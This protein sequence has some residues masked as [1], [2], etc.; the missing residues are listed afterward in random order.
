[1]RI[2]FLHRWVGVHGGGTETHIKALV[3][4]FLERG[5]EV[6]IITRAGDFPLEGLFPKARVWRVAGNFR[7]SDHSYEDWRVY[8]HTALFIIKL[9]IKLLYLHFRGERFDVLSVHF[10]TEAVVARV[11]RALFKTPFGNI[12]EGY[13][14][15]E[16]KVARWADQP[17]TISEY[18]AQRYKQNFGIDSVVIPNGADQKRF[19]ERVDGSEIRQKYCQDREKLVVTV[20]RLEPR[21]D[22]PTLLQAAVAAHEKMPEVRFVIAGTGI[23]AA[24]LKSQSSQLNTQGYVTFAG[25]VSDEDLPRYYAAADLFVLPT[26][27]EGFG[28]VYAEAMSCGI[29]ILTTDIPAAR[30]VVG[31]AGEF[32]PVK[33]PKILAEKI[34]SILRDPKKMAKMGAASLK[35]AGRYDWEKL[36]ADYEKVYKEAA[37]L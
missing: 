17:I 8:P 31:E 26:L 33:S 16:G 30:E 3:N 22:I 25:F 2:L 7:E 36:A 9:L 5:H 21:K 18:E 19:N 35:R 32:V 23:N 1:M 37:G 28:I 34:V 6:G 4:I 10:P 13:T 12:L 27:E 24:E 14:P 15:L 11:Y 20:C 29:P